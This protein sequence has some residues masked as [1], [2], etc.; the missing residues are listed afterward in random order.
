MRICEEIQYNSSSFAGSLTMFSAYIKYLI[1]EFY[2]YP[3][4]CFEIIEIE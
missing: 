4:S 3:Q 2:Y 1:D